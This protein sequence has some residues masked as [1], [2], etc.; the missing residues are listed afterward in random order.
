M[1][2]PTSQ[3]QTRAQARVQDRGSGPPTP[4]GQS[5]R[6]DALVMPAAKTPVSSGAIAT[7]GFVLAV[8]L[9]AAGVAAVRDALVYAGVLDGTPLLSLAARATNGVT[10]AVWMVPVGVVLAVLGLWLLLMALRPR[11]RKAVTLTAQTGVF[12]RPK[13]VSRLAETAAERIGGVLDVRVS[14]KPKTAKVTVRSTGDQ[15]TSD[16]V[17]DAV[18]ARLAPLESP[19][20]LKIRSTGGAS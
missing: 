7:L 14:A 18:T 10:P 4:A 16:R 2:S 12:L 13:D 17:R 6:A 19:P 20:T 3:P 11:P 1:S 9:T 8:L 5:G 15:A